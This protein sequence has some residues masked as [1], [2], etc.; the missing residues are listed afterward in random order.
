MPDP[1]DA[2]KMINF[3]CF[4][5]QSPHSKVHNDIRIPSA[6]SSRNLR[7][8]SLKRSKLRAN[9]TVQK[10]CGSPSKSLLLILQ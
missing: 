3:T 5:V 9:L 10:S 2:S 4:Y 8:S 6:N 7:Y 1:A